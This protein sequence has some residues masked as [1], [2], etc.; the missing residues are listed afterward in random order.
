[1]VGQAS[2]I[3]TT[4]PKEYEYL[5]FISYKRSDEKWARWLQ[6]RLER[7]KIPVSLKKSHPDL[8]DNLRPIFRDKTDLSGGGLTEEILSALDKAKYLIVLCSP[9]AAKSEWVSKEITYFV[10]SGRTKNII[11]YIISGQPFAEDP[12]IECFPPQLR[13]L[14]GDSEILGINLNEVGKNA[15]F[16]KLVSRLLTVSYDSLWERYRRNIKRYKILGTLI[17]IVLSAIFG[18][19]AFTITRNKLYG[20]MLNITH[21]ATEASKAYYEKDFV[22]VVSHAVKGT[23]KEVYG[24]K[25]VS[26]DLLR[27]MHQAYDMYQGLNPIL[28]VPGYDNN[29][30]FDHFDVGVSLDNNRYYTI[31]DGVITLFDLSS[32]NAISQIDGKNC[33]FVNDGLYLVADKTDSIVVYNS[34]DMLRVLAVPQHKIKTIHGKSPFENTWVTSSDSSTIFISSDSWDIVRELDGIPQS[35]N[36]G[37]CKGVDEVS[38]MYSN[39]GAYFVTTTDNS[40]CIHDMRSGQIV[41]QSKGIHWAKDNYSFSLAE[42]I[43]VYKTDGKIIRVNLR[44][45]KEDV[46]IKESSAICYCYDG[47]LL[48]IVT[49]RSRLDSNYRNYKTV[50]IIDIGKG[51][52]RQIL[53]LE[54]VVMFVGFLNDKGNQYI[55]TFSRHATNMG[56]GVFTLW[57]RETGK[58]LQAETLI[59]RYGLPTSGEYGRDGSFVCLTYLNSIVAC[60]SLKNSRLYVYRPHG[61]YYGNHSVADSYDEIIGIINGENTVFYSTRNSSAIGA[62]IVFTENK[63]YIRSTNEVIS[64]STLEPILTSPQQITWF[65]EDAV[66]YQTNSGTFSV[67]GNTMITEHNI[68]I[69]PGSKLAVDQYC[70]YSLPGM[71]VLDSLSISHQYNR[72]DKTVT[73]ATTTGYLKR[74]D[75]NIGRLISSFP[76]PGYAKEFSLNQKTMLSYRRDRWD[77]DDGIWTTSAINGAIDK[78]LFVRKSPSKDHHFYAYDLYKN[79]NFVSEISDGSQ[80]FGRTNYHIIPS[81]NH[82]VLF[83]DRGHIVDLESSVELQLEEKIEKMQCSGDAKSFLISKGNMVKHYTWDGEVLHEYKAPS[84]IQLDPMTLDFDILNKSPVINSERIKYERFTPQRDSAIVSGFYEDLNWKNKIGLRSG[85]IYHVET[86]DEMVA[87]YRNLYKD[88][89]RYEQ[90]Q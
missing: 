11:P 52:V 53:E 54:S 15:S 17:A 63:K 83:S 47:D 71:E 28:T 16:I 48:A 2:N 73:V 42:D 30:R 32:H 82:F 89:E 41:Y 12:N 3:N 68:N 4:G 46:L 39:S 62:G 40:Y 38:R 66:Y 20:E 27:I 1:M 65:S 70:L 14:K 72:Q 80:S 5:A 33:S 50:I 60:V 45:K 22:G 6:N 75:C 55:L 23:P 81:S 36:N 19:L 21:H 35:S 69:L 79:D 84:A 58:K 13:A 8:P 74:Y 10:D 25:V 24:S 57:D 88:I 31:S 67:Q 86:A 51:L 37:L 43:F 49:N 77:F 7:Y 85:I 64:S 44:T 9:E 76:Y 61:H 18:M 56:E 29:N 34:E 90:R 78:Y 87:H 59:T 26:E